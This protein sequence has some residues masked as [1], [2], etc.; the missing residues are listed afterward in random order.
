MRAKG[1]AQTIAIA[2]FVL[3]Y[4]I[5]TLLYHVFTTIWKWRPKRAQ[6]IT[7]NYD[8][9]HVFDCVAIVITPTKIVRSTGRMQPEVHECAPINFQLMLQFRIAPLSSPVNISASFGD[10]KIRTIGHECALF[11]SHRKT[12]V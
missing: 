2:H 8:C 1:Q 7:V 10:N 6:S 12:K 5:S 3:Y 9:G 11:R 4:T